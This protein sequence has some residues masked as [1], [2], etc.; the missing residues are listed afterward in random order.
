MSKK[1]EQSILGLPPL[2]P[3][4]ATFSGTE[5]VAYNPGRA[6]TPREEDIWEEWHI[7]KVIITAIDDKAQYGLEQ[8]NGL[9]WFAAT[10]VWYT[11]Q[12]IEGVRQEAQGTGCQAAMDEFCKYLT[13]LSA[14]HTLGVVEVSAGKIAEV[15]GESVVPPPPPA[16]E[17]RKGFFARLFGG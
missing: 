5:L 2:P 3:L 14:R 11:F 13:T 6:I 10:D 15:V 16:P 4:A 1:R 7:D 9:K 17:P 8:M 12:Q